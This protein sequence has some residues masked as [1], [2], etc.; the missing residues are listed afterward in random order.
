MET[1]MA[2]KADSGLNGWR[3]ARWTIPAGLLTVPLVAHFPWIGS[4]FVVMGVL[5]FG[6][7]GIYE[8]IARASTSLAYRAAAGVAVAA[9]FLL[10]WINLAVGIIGSENNPLNLLYAGVI[11][12]ALIGAIVARFEPKGMPRALAATAL[13]QGL[14]GGVAAFGGPNDPPGS[15]GQIALNGGFAAL[16]L[17]SAALFRKA[18]R[19][20]AG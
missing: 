18:A 11:G 4:N 8:A 1:A 7:V 16:W 15:V 5:L 3:I 9:S 13:A 12:V 6:S 2:S 14:V 10:I 19:D 17:L 20:L